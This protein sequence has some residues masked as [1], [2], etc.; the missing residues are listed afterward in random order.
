MYIRRSITI[1]LV[2]SAIMLAVG[3]G[4]HAIGSA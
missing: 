1:V 2:A 4:P 3:A